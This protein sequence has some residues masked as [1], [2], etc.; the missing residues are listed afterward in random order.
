MLDKISEVYLNESHFKLISFRSPSFFKPRSHSS[1]LYRR[2]PHTHS[3]S[4]PLIIISEHKASGIQLIYIFQ[5]LSIYVNADFL[6]QEKGMI[7]L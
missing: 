2:L 3:L 4:Q 7:Y 1:T 5:W 6:S